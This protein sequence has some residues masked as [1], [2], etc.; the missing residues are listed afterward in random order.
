MMNSTFSEYT[1]TLGDFF[2]VRTSG[3]GDGEHLLHKL[4]KAEFR[5][6]PLPVTIGQLCFGFSLNNYFHS[7]QVVD[8]GRF[9]VPTAGVKG[10]NGYDHVAEVLLQYSAVSELSHGIA[11]TSHKSIDLGKDAAQRP[12]VIRWFHLPS[13]SF[14]VVDVLGRGEV[15]VAAL[16]QNYRVAALVLH[17]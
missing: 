5:Y 8:G 4:D 11:P 1:K 7:V 14:D 17:G 16:S 13:Y 6:R 2:D 9:Q 3:A 15:H 12:D 10:F